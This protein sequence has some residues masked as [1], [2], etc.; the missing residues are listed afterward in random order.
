MTALR[1]RT[2]A[3]GALILGVAGI[4]PACS[5]DP[6][7]PV[8]GNAIV[9][10]GEEC[11]DGNQSDSDSCTSLCLSA[12][13]GDAFVNEGVEECDD[14]NVDD[15]DECSNE[16]RSARC[17]DGIVQTALEA[18]DDGN[19]S[20]FDRC[21]NLCARATCGDGIVRAGVE[22]CDD[23]ND[24]DEDGC[25]TGCSLP[26]CGDGLVQSGEECDD[27]NLVDDDGC[28]NRCLEAS[29]GNGLVEEGEE[30]DDGDADDSDAC[31]AGCVAASCGDGVV[32]LGVEGCDD[33][34]G[35]GPGAACT[36]DCAPASCGDGLVHEGVEEC[37]DGNA[38]DTDACTSRCL[39]P[40]CGDGTVQ[41]GEE[42]DDGN[43]D[44]SDA[45][46]PE[47]VS[48]ICGDGVLQV[49][50]EA[51]DDGNDDDSDGCSS[52]CAPTSC[53][54]GVVQPGEA[55]DDGNT[56]DRDDCT[57][58]CLSADCGDGIVHAGVEACDDGN[59]DDSDTCL[60]ECVEAR[61]GDGVVR[62]GVEGCD[63]GN[64]VDDDACSNV[65]APASCGD[66]RVQ[67]PEL[68]DDGNTDDG[69]AC[70]TRCVPATCGDGVV[71]RGVELC[72]DGNNVD[73]DG[74]G[75][76]CGAESRCGDGIVDAPVEDCDD[77]NTDD[78]DACRNDCTPAF[79]GDG[80]VWTGVEV[81]DDGNDSDT[82]ACR[83]ACTSALCGDG[84][85]WAGVEAC[86]DAN[87]DETDACQSDCTE[88]FCGDGII[89]A[90]VEIC[91]DANL[92]NLDGCLI[93]CRHWDP[94]AETRLDE[95]SPGSACLG[96]TPDVIRIIGAGFLR[97]RGTNP[98]VLFD[99]SDAAGVTM[100]GCRSIFGVFE[101]IETCEEIEIA[102]PDGLLVGEYP[103]E[104]VNNVPTECGG[105]G[106]FGVGPPP[107]IR[108]IEPAFI[109]EGSPS[110]ELVGDGFLTTSEVFV[111]DVRAEAVTL[112]DEDR[113][114]AT[115]DEL[116]PGTY[117]VRV[118]NGDS[119]DAVE[120][121]FVEVVPDPR[122]FFV[123]P[124]ILYNGI[125]VRATVYVANINGDVVSS[126][127]IRPAG[128]AA[129]PTLLADIAYDPARPSE[130]QARIPAGLAPGTYE[131]ILTDGLG[132]TGVAS[133]AFR[134][135]GTVNL[136]LEA[137]VPPFAW[138]DADSSVR[139]LA[140]DAPPV[141]LVG[142][143]PGVRL[144]A[145]PVTGDTA[146]AFESVGFVSASE[147]TAVVAEGL[148]PGLY[149][150]IAVNPDG[151]V[152]IVS[153]GFTVLANPL[154][155]IDSV[156]P[157]SIPNS[158]PQTLEIE[159]SGFAAGAAVDLHCLAPEGGRSIVPATVDAIDD[160]GISA[161]VAPGLAAGTVCVVRVTNVDTGFGEF[162]AIGVTTPA[163]NIPAF[164]LNTSMATARRY[165]A[166]AVGNITG[167]SR[168]LYAIGGDEG[169]EDS[170]LDS[171]EVVT[172]DRFGVPGIW[173]PEPQRL[174]TPLTHARAA[175]I[176]GYVYLVG[177]S[178]GAASV[179]DVRRA[180]VL[181]PADTP[182]FER[183]GVAEGDDGLVPGLWFYR[184]TA[185][186]PDDDNW[187]PAG[188]T[189]PSE[190]Q[191]VRIPLG[192]DRPLHIT[193]HWDPVDRVDHYRIYRTAGPDLSTGDEQLLAVVPAET[194]EFTDVGDPTSA[195]RPPRLG[196]LGE[197]ASL[198]SLRTSRAGLGLAVAPDPEDD[199]VVHLYAVGGRDGAGNPLSSYELLSIDHD[200]DLPVVSPSWT[201][202]STGVDARWLTIAHT[203]N[204]TVT[205]AT[206]EG[207]S[208]VYWGS[209]VGAGDSNLRD[210]DVAEV[211][212]GGALSAFRRDSSISPT[213]I[214]HSG[215]AIANQLFGFG[216][217]NR[218]PANNV[219][220]TLIECDGG[221][222]PELVNWNNAGI[223]LVV[224]RY[225]S[226]ALL[227]SGR[228][229]VLGGA[230]DD[231][232]T[233]TVES[234][235]W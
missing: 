145:S 171:V 50:I 186:R 47:C 119:C 128:S 27:G 161:T 201:E 21:T 160:E 147:L 56:D 90:G 81:C 140:D 120:E 121:D 216:G 31:L 144:Y 63:D 51:C 73:G 79:C 134:V 18:C 197:W 146:T 133:T 163:E 70:T 25:S 43:A 131:L 118:S 82:D 124:E 170:A 29:C 168:T 11:D 180:R 178:D 204:R 114:L 230:A 215:V 23:G 151:S 202:I 192:L 85:V 193:L 130:V 157:A 195:P 200:D 61:C 107:T 99:G 5:D 127:G 14:G 126:L 196:D 203:V 209:G 175:E 54:D 189:L 181:S 152:G 9:E 52:D 234:T 226:A 208:Y 20:D 188:E 235:V 6:I 199:D 7:E 71:R 49:G 109:C 24:V 112:V 210:Y 100:L 87:D 173:R 93:D 75:A 158:S 182:E 132:C 95:I 62:V 2:L 76:D 213:V 142:F 122:V 69:D 101:T 1:Q 35:N 74:C 13:C 165:P 164:E 88:S 64:D 220:S 223:S 169:T 46:T 66:G 232:P 30:C 108:G 86:D 149:D 191:P 115:F 110:F 198:P 153:R 125:S 184:V 44:D 205:T 39:A 33:G 26:T 15:R 224:E 45:C 57:S 22:A 10:H 111:G 58:R 207:D 8:C 60:S 148:T 48:A 137:I 36:E 227:A 103:I 16:C 150:V 185:V 183:I 167:T 38:D 89:H 229:F 92:D 78:F 104:V 233:A 84:I 155:L 179:A 80:V 68:C 40:S 3:L 221:T 37:D 231:G 12:R 222:C 123:D 154:P 97:I 159:G 105:I 141:G 217:Q 156:T 177:G 106:F 129:E 91:D 116:D 228:I 28:S 117:D 17:G 94:C 166:A 83:T 218:R 59:A 176:G 72:D 214:G 102:V 172:L 98:I 96:A 138:T 174:P 211:L 32:H 162:S 113:L 77:G 65:C 187:N 34:D 194:T 135:T 219:V 136:A 139:A 67:P 143:A 190:P 225:L 53:G 212:A 42:C 55:C 19:F 4:G 41:E 206:G